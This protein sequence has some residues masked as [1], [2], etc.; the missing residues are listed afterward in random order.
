MH[1]IGGGG[2][3]PA[4]FLILATEGRQ[5]GHLAEVLSIRLPRHCRGRRQAGVA[6]PVRRAGRSRKPS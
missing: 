6:I 4:E 3:I 5:V 1:K 2:V